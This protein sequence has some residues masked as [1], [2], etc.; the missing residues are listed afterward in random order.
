MKTTVSLKYFVND[1]FWK[2]LFAS[3]S[4]LTPSNLISL[5]VLVTLKLFA[6]FKHKIRAILASCKKLLNFT[7]LGN[8]FFD[9]FTEVEI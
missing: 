1:G 7:L 3:K 8:C 5:T 6:Q 9:L 2:Q 4:P